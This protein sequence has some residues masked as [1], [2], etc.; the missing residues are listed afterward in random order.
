MITEF[1]AYAKAESCRMTMHV[2]SSPD[3]RDEARHRFGTG[4]I[5]RLSE[6][7]A[8]GPHL[9][10]AHCVWCDETERRLLAESQTG[11]SHNPVANL[12]YAAGVAPL[13]ITD[14]RS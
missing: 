3:E 9:L 13:A 4:S 6:L 12:M 5:E 1:T 10:I 2:A 11:V 7:D 8:L 14:T